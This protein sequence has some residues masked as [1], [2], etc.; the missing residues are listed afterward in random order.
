MLLGDFLDRLSP[1][2]RA[3]ITKVLNRTAEGP[4]ESQMG[5]LKG[6]AM[7]GFVQG[8]DAEIELIKRWLEVWL[9][10][11]RPFALLRTYEDR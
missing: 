6:E 1:N 11:R 8:R 9:H 7:M 5:I 3:G 10:Q 4:D 2:V